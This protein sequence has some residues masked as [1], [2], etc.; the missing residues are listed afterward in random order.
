MNKLLSTSLSLIGTAAAV[1][2]TAS[3]SQAA[4]LS[5][6]GITGTADLF[7][8]GGTY[9]SLQDAGYSATGIEVDPAKSSTNKYLTPGADTV[10]SQDTKFQN[11]STPGVRS[12]SVASTGDKPDGVTSEIEITGLTGALSFLWGSV[13]TYNTINFF[14]GGTNVGSLTGTTLATALGSFTANTAG[15]YN[16]ILTL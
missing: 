16:I 6:G 2:L 5:F 13:D 1:A 12:Y 15:N 4:A 14:D 11:P 8:V 9:S 10:F 7:T 3:A